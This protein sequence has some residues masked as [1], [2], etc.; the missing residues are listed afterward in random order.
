MGPR[1]GGPRSRRP[2]AARSMPS[3]LSSGSV[4]SAARSSP[5]TAQ[6]PQHVVGPRLPWLAPRETERAAVPGGR[7][8]PKAVWSWR[9]VA[10]QRPE[11][12]RHQQSASSQ[13]RAPAPA[14]AEAPAARQPES[15][16]PPPAHAE[17]AAARPPT[18]GASKGQPEER[19]PSSPGPRSAAPPATT[20]T[21]APPGEERGAAVD[22][23]GRGRTRFGPFAVAIAV[24]RA[25]VTSDDGGG[26]GDHGQPHFSRSCRAPRLSS[27]E[28]QPG[29]CTLS[30]PPGAAP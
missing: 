21:A 4:C 28:H 24:V 3:S 8:D 10:E 14:H 26:S 29:P 18:E 30:Q 27:S 7:G 9:A 2:P 13:S 19:R 12:S 25:E 22:G 20:T 17:A 16:P 15:R 5:D 11:S 23:R 6:L 1:Q